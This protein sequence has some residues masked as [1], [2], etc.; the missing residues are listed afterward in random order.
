VLSGLFGAEDFAVRAVHR[1]ASSGWY[2]HDRSEGDRREIAGHSG[3]PLD[4]HEIDELYNLALSEGLRGAV[5]V[6]A[7]PTD[8]S[9][10]PPETYRRLAADLRSNG[11]RVVADLSGDHLAAAVAGGLTCLKV[12]HEELIDDGRARD[13]SR[14]ELSAAARRL[15]AEGAEAVVVSRSDQPAIALLDGELVQVEAPRLEEADA[16][17]A[18]DSMTAAVAAVLARGADLREAVRVGAAAGAVNVTRHG[19]GTGHAEAVAEVAKR[20]RLVSIPE[21]EPGEVA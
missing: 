18:G 20:V 16:R 1:S 5:S 4:R 17:G 12:S 13:G 21:H 14:R 11:A 2:V 8:P 9:L 7:G 15:R 19:L 3:E 10:V 6:L